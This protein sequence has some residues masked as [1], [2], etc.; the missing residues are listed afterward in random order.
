MMD[1]T[2]FV[3]GRWKRVIVVVFAEDVTIKLAGQMRLGSTPIILHEDVWKQPSSWL[4]RLLAIRF[5]QGI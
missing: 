3:D 4:Q 1:M 5:G 2:K